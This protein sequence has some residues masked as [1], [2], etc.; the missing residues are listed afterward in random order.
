MVT[1][2]SDEDEYDKDVAWP[3]T[4]A[5]AKSLEHSF[6]KVFATPRMGLGR[7]SL[8]LNNDVLIVNAAGNDGLT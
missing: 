1:H 3:V 5:L 6:G 8:C 7:H 2:C 4:A